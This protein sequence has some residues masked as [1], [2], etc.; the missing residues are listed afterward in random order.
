MVSRSENNRCCIGLKLELVQS[1]PQPEPEEPPPLP[2]DQVFPSPGRQNSILSLTF[3]EIQLK[4]GKS[5]GSM[6]IDEFLAN[7]WSVDEGPSS[8]LPY[9]QNEP[10]NNNKALTAPGPGRLLRQSSFSIPTPLCNKTVDE[11]WFEIHKD[12]AHRQ[13]SAPSN[14]NN[15]ML[16]RRQQTFGEMTLEDFLVRARILH[17]PVM[18]SHPKFASS[19]LKPPPGFV[20][21]AVLLDSSYG[22]RNIAGFGVIS[23]SHGTGSNPSGNGFGTNYSMVYG[24]NSISCGAQSSCSALNERSHGFLEAFRLKS[25]GIVDGPPEMVVE[26]RQ[27]RMIKNRESAARSRARRQVRGSERFFVFLSLG[28]K[29]GMS[30]PK[31]M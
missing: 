21:S 29:F 7:I 3:D 18:P 26:R 17:E 6:N 9:S 13:L 11:V 16:P 20:D 8:S 4:S 5:F 27:R 28:I 24:N 2:N 10:T 22:T 14:P 15:S 23:S 25:K 19:F 30:Y 31:H 1:P 12:Q